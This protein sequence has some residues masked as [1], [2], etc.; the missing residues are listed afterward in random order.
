MNLRSETP[1]KEFDSGCWVPACWKDDAAVRG[2]GEVDAVIAQEVLERNEALRPNRAL[3]LR[4]DRRE[5]GPTSE[6]SSVHFRFSRLDETKRFVGI[7]I[8]PLRNWRGRR[9]ALFE[10]RDSPRNIGG[11]RWLQH[12][13]ASGLFRGCV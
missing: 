5:V 6:S 1:E 4:E 8:E 12:T 9:L 3:A 13:R 10:Q 11:W 2:G 7:V